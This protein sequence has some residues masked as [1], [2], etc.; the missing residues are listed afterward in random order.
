MRNLARTARPAPAPLPDRLEHTTAEG[1]SIQVT[2]IEINLSK[3]I[4]VTC[5]VVV[6]RPDGVEQRVRATIEFPDETRSMLLAATWRDGESI[7]ET[8]CEAAA[9]YLAD[10]GSSRIVEIAGGGA[11]DFSTGAPHATIRLCLP[12]LRSVL[13]I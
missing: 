4:S 8:I 3:N 13:S 7:G 1:A 9:T 2:P 5:M 11:R 6:N 10:Y 12:D